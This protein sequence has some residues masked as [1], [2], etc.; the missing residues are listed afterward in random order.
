VAGTAPTAASQPT[1]AT[2]A[3]NAAAPDAVFDRSLVAWWAVWTVIALAAFGVLTAII[4]NPIFGRGIPAAPFA[5][6]VWLASAPL[7][8]LVMATYFAP[9][10]ARAAMPLA[11]G[12]GRDGTTLGTIGGLAVFFAIGCPTCNKIA[13]LLLGASGAVSVFGPIQP[14]IGLASLALLGVTVAW[15]LR[16]RARGGTCRVPA[17]PPA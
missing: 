11:V 12:G 17:D 5:I 2:S 1:A 14:F 13:L 7:M 9:P 16:L 4:P 3:S 8:G 6:G 15:R 10:P